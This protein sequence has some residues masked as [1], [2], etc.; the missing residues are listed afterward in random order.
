METYH[1]ALSISERGKVI[2]LKRTVLERNVNNYNPFFLSIWNANC[3]LQLCLDNYAVITYITDYFS[4]GDAGLTR[5]LMKA[6]KEK[7][8]EYS[9]SELKHYLKR[10]F[11]ISRQVCVSEA[12]YRLVQGLDLKGSNV[13]SKHVDTSIPEKRAA[14][15]RWVGEDN[16][17]KEG[18]NESDSE[19]SDEDDNDGKTPH[20]PK[21]KGIK[22]KGREGHF[23]QSQSIHDRYSM[24][25]ADLEDICMAQFITHYDNC[26]KPKTANFSSNGCCYVDV[27]EPEEKKLQ[28]KIYA[29]GK[30]LP[31]YILLSNG[32]CLRLRAIPRI[33]G[34][35]HKKQDYEILYSEII[36]FLPWFE[37]EELYAEDKETVRSIYLANQELIELNKK[38]IFP[39]SKRIEEIR[40]FINNN[41]ENKAGHLYDKV[42]VTAEAE[43]ENEEVLGEMEQPDLNTLPEE[44][45]EPKKASNM[46]AKEELKLRPIVIADRATLRRSVRGLSYE[47]RL[48]FD[49]VIHY[50]RC[51]AIDNL[52]GQIDPEPPKYIVHGEFA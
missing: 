14:Y 10:V 15:F 26:K 24:R 41:E 35:H 18:F 12:T 11:I 46:S 17:E 19:N 49:D 30:V 52:G 39:N 20:Y 33:I 25:P 36:L 44:P 27:K 9:D 38:R 1:K 28:P 5:L 7:K 42:D 43:Q 48:V 37:E 31:K 4:K 47:Q 40:E 8:D 13:A 29:T 6:L 21:G 16:D 3:D 50:C 45:N 22:I 2:I 32:A 23:I 51:V 34:L